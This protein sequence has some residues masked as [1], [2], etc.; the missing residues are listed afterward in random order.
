M[1]VGAEWLLV[2][3]HPRDAQ[4]A[5]AAWDAVEGGRE[6]AEVEPEGTVVVHPIYR[7]PD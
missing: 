7:S 6:M 4:E 5:Q 2:T 3:G 1:P